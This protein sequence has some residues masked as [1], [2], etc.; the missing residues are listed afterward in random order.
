VELANRE[1]LQARDQLELLAQMDPLTEALNRHAF[2]SL[3]RRPESGH[4]SKTSGSVAVLDIDNLKPIND[5]LGHTAGDKAIRAVARA[6]R[7]LVRA[8]DMLFRW[9]GDEFLVL[10][11]NLPQAEARRRMEKLNQILD[12]NCR[13]WTGVPLTVTV[14]HGVA[15]FNSLTDLGSAIEKADQAMYAQRHQARGVNR[16]QPAEESLGEA[17]F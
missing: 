1:L 4:E 7:S 6:M 10:M 8:D 13:R 11:F 17:V 15:G 12:E 2:H 9:G 5:T 16:P 3:L 14:S